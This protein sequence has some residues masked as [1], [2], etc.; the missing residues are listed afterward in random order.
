LF[1]TFIRSRIFF[2]RHAKQQTNTYLD[3]L[4]KFVDIVNKHTINVIVYIGFD[5]YAQFQRK[6][7]EECQGVYLEEDNVPI[8]E[9][10]RMK[11]EDKTRYAA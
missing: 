5:I 6:E 9:G 3:N 2:R 10:G 7:R 4:H 8:F 1:F 11:T